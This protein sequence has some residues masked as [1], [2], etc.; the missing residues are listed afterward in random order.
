M[1]ALAKGGLLGISAVILIFGVPLVM[2]YRLLFA[3]DTSPEARRM[4]IAGLVLLLSFMAFALTE[5]IFGRYRSMTFFA[6]YLTV[7]M[8][9]MNSSKKPE[10]N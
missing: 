6:F 8:A 5:A 9:F 1:S 2:F 4:A 3:D 7:L 10:N